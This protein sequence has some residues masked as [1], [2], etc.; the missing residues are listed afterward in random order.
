MAVDPG[1]EDLY[2]S[3]AQTVFCAV[4]LQCRDRA[5]AE[6]ATQEAFA[7]GLERWDRLRGQVWAIG[8]AITT[9]LNAPSGQCAD[10]G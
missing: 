3:E 7:R 10:A 2:R 9:A 6:D 8:W 5:V 4:F 1:F